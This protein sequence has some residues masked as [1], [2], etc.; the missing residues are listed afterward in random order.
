MLHEY[1]TLIH[2][3]ASGLSQASI[4]GASLGGLWLNGQN[5]HPATNIR[6]DPGVPDSEGLLTI[7]VKN[8]VAQDKE[9]LE[10]GN[11]FYTRPVI[12]FDMALF[13]SP[14]Q[15]AGAV[16]G[17]LVQ[18][19]LPD[20]LFLLLA[21]LV[22]T[23]TAYMTFKKYFK[24]R[25][26]ENEARAASGKEDEALAHTGQLIEQSLK[27]SEEPMD[28]NTP[29]K[30]DSTSK[31]IESLE[32]AVVTTESAAIESLE[33]AELTTQNAAIESL[34]K[35]M[36]ENADESDQELLLRKLY[37]SEDMRQYP[38]EKIAGLVVLWVGLVVLTLIKG[39]KGVESLVGINCESPWY[40]VVI[41]VQFCWT[42]GIA[43]LYALK[44][45]R[46]QKQRVAVRYPFH[47]DDLSWDS[48]SLQFNGFFTFI[49]GIVAG[50]VGIGGGMVR[51]TAVRNAFP[52]LNAHVD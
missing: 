22:L 26:K 51:E 43:L 33:E 7:Q 40:G 27:N 25:S 39:G 15:M 52:N 2:T 12:D 19:L 46:K 18:T 11:E 8:T 44:L 38:K 36:N 28:N 50:L 5:L 21:G 41:A 42:F 37:L 35:A 3:Q 48:H 24:A 10:A 13:L 4:F 1:L 6:S 17:V 47:H 30:A 16:L 49:S 9:Y 14:M 31:A 32:E 34:N 29:N 23:F 20:W 45:L